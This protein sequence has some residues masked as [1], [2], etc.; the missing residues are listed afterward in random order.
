[1]VCPEWEWITSK[2]MGRKE[3]SLPSE[4]Q[5]LINRR[6]AASKLRGLRTAHASLKDFATRVNLDQSY[7]SRIERGKAP[8]QDKLVDIYLESFVVEGEAREILK[9]ELGLLYGRAPH[10][11]ER[12]AWAIATLISE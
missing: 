5:N 3:T 8:A 9:V 2:Y 4:S 10:L 7:L 12:Q 6:I 1:M 11:S